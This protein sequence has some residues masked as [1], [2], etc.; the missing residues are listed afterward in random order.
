MKVS[1]RKIFH[2]S[3]VVEEGKLKNAWAKQIMYY[4]YKLYHLLEFP[5]MIALNSMSIEKFN[6]N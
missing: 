6:V 5:S 4:S 1:R 3:L 2:Y